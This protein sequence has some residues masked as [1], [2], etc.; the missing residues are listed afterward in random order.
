MLPIIILAAGASERL[1]QPKQ[2]LQYRER[3]LLRNVVETALASL[4]RPVIVVLGAFADQIRPEVENTEV[5][6]VFN[7]NWEEGMS[8]SIR[9]GL[10]AVREVEQE[11]EGVMFMVCD[12]PLVSASLLESLVVAYRESGLPMAACEYGEEPGVPALF[13]R[14]LFPELEALRGTEGAKRVLRR[15]RSEIATIPFP[16]GVIDIDTLEDYQ[17]L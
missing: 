13:D 11:S 16:E 9:A 6:V 5:S 7:S 1:G 2:L 15:H 4:C 10:A 12:Q 14:S 8:A 3:T 17:A